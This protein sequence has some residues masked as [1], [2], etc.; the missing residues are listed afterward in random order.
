[1]IDSVPCSGGGRCSSHSDRVLLPRPPDSPV[2]EPASLSLERSRVAGEVVPPGKHRGDV[3]TEARGEH[4]ALEG[5]ARVDLRAIATGPAA[6]LHLQHAATLVDLQV[7]HRD[8]Q[9]LRPS[10]ET[11]D[12]HDRRQHVVP[13]Y[14]HL[15]AERSAAQP[16]GSQ[17]VDGQYCYPGH[18]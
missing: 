11:A 5:I 1:M 15:H 2:S 12:R 8:H 3:V 9:M 13:G 6:D 16:V 4:Q 7:R 10:E 14:H 17:A 18:Q